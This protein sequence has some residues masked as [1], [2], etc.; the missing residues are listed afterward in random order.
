MQHKHLRFG[1][2]FRV[3]LGNPRSQAAQMTL[4]PGATEGGP[5]NRHSG[6]DQWLF[7]VGGDGLAI[8]EGQSV[9][10]RTGTLVLIS[11]CER[12]EIRNTGREPLQT[13]NIYVPPAY[14]SDGDE[15][16]AGKS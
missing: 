15:R 14:D 13:F 12:H 9:E 10:L 5:D 4:P 2:G 16:R 7:V 6:S 1:K 3:V 11:Q 8:V